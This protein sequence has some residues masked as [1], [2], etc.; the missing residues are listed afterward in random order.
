MQLPKVII[1]DN[2]FDQI[3]SESGIKRL[4]RSNETSIVGLE[5]FL[6]WKVNSH[7]HTNSNSSQSIGTRKAYIKAYWR[8][9]LSKR[10][11]KL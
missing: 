10:V 2:F 7:E 9:N 6:H 11:K 4:E 5:L 8:V 3:R 1:A